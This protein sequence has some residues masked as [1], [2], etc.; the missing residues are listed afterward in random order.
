V[1]DQLRTNPAVQFHREAIDQTSVGLDIWDETNAT[2]ENAH[3]LRSQALQ[4]FAAHASTQHNNGRLVK[5]V[6]LMSSTGKI[7]IMASIFAMASN[8][9]ITEHHNEKREDT[10]LEI[11]GNQPAV[12]KDKPK[13]RKHGNYRRKKKL[14]DLKREANKKSNQLAAIATNLGAQAFNTR[15]KTIATSL[16]SKADNLLERSSDVKVRTMMATFDT[17]EE[18]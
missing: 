1:L 2:N 9:F 11:P 14:L 8:D 16:K 3:L 13:W 12:A 15:M 10:R 6:A 7:E 17:P 5:L 18:P 4:F